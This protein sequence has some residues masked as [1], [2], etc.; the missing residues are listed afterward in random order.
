MCL[1]AVYNL[2]CKTFEIPTK[3]HYEMLIFIL[4]GFKTKEFLYII[5]LNIYTYY[6]LF[7][8]SDL[9][10]VNRSFKLYQHDA[11]LSY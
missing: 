8:M 5:F 4:H 2:R 9:L 11:C 10:I 3:N 6:C 1:D 7:I